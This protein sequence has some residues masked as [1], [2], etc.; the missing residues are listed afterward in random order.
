M[1]MSGERTVGLFQPGDS[2]RMPTS[3]SDGSSE[4]TIGPSKRAPFSL[5]KTSGIELPAWCLHVTHH[6][7]D[8][9]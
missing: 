2:E 6:D 5:R 8:T 3:V 4:I 9:P 1:G 7:A